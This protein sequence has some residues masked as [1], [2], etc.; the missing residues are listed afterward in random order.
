MLSAKCPGL[1]VESVRK[2]SADSVCD[3]WMGL[4]R[5]ADLRGGVQSVR[6]VSGFEH[7][8]DSP[9]IDTVRIGAFEP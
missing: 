4:P 6:K 9:Y 5:R 2:V 7:D 3:S 1:S 8:I